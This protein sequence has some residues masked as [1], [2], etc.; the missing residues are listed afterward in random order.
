[1]KLN[2]S[3][4]VI[5]L[6]TVF[7][8]INMTSAQELN[9]GLIKVFIDGEKSVIEFAK[10]EINFI[11]FV[12]NPSQADVHIQIFNQRTGNR[13][14]EYTVALIGQDQF[15]GMDDEYK[16]S[17]PE[18]STVLEQNDEIIKL[19]K[20]GLSR[21]VFQTPLHK[22]LDIKIKNEI[23]DRLVQ[24]EDDWDSWIFKLGFKGAVQGEESKREIQWKINIDVDR[25]TESSKIKIDAEYSTEIK[26]FEDDEN[27]SS[28]SKYKRSLDFLY[29]ASLTDHFSSGFFTDIKSR[30]YDNIKLGYSFAPA[31]E[32]NISPYSESAR[33][34]FAILYLVEFKKYEYYETTIFMKNAE[35]L[36]GQ[37]LALRYKN[38]QPWGEAN[39]ELS[40]SN[41]FYDFSKNRIE[42]NTE[43][44]FRVFGNFSFDLS[45]VFSLVNDQIYLPIEGATYEEILLNQKKLLSK[46]EYDL[47][48]GVK[49]TFGSIYNDVVNPRFE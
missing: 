44:A 31:V 39:I 48:F 14:W 15:A 46:Y 35:N 17:F 8:S 18:E 34:L 3:A 47:A 5:I 41:Y 26:E 21:Y 19:I 49:Y 32:Y 2:K 16:T 22:S 1:M 27:I 6:I 12:R 23:G 7:S 9:D 37:K 10:E 43:L 38:I 28:N 40:A 29:V 25:V 33:N 11:H 4:F 42:L 36:I 24:V 45:G 20:A 13:G 30:T